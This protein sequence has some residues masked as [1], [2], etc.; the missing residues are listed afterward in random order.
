MHHVVA[1]Q[2]THRHKVKMR[3]AQ[4]TQLVEERRKLLAYPVE[5]LLAI[6]DQVHL[7]HRHQ[8]VRH[9]QQR[10]N[11]RMPPRLN[12]HTLPRIHQHNRE[13]R[14]RRARSHIPRVLFMPRRIRDYELP[15]RRSKIAVRH[16][17]RDSL[18]TLRPQAIRQQRQVQHTRRRRTLARNRPQ[19]ILI[20]RLR[21]IQQPSN[22]RRFPIIH[23]ACRR[24]SQQIPSMIFGQKIGHI[25][26]LPRR[27]RRRLR[28]MPKAR[29]ERVD[30]LVP[31]LRLTR[32]RIV[33][34]CFNL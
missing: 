10:R 6:L 11:A 15:P 13:R 2:R 16:I 32:R 17:D 31:D 24:K 26:V 23:R 19:I 12:Q 18:L 29:I 14:R 28:R 22:Q 7:V 34:G 3:R 25:E 30:P 4:L 27:H 20:H 8:D 5:N 21:V 33:V 1:R 9:A